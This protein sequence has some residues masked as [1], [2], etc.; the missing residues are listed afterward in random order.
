MTNTCGS[1]FSF[2]NGPRKRA[3]T[4]PTNKLASTANPQS[5]ASASNS[6]LKLEFNDSNGFL[7]NLPH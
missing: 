4:N 5:L 2:N 7:H 6:L 1:D 3:L